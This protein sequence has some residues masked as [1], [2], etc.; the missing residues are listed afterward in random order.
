[1][2]E[3]YTT[4]WYDELKNLLNSNPD[5]AKSAPQ[6]TLKMLGQFYGDG[7]SP[8]L[9]AGEQR[10]FVILLDDGK[11][12]DYYEVAES[13]P[14][15]DFDFI[16]EIPAAVFE[17]VAAGSVDPVEAGLKGTIKITG[18][19]RILIRHA[20]LVNVMKDVYTRDVETTWPKGKPPY[21]AGA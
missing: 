14:R 10:F 5:L 21:G 9:S 20:D 12:T 18:D 2:P 6:G 15:K 17:E 1:M 8:Y 3:I 19:M 4:E 7:R 13:P 11:C 16:F